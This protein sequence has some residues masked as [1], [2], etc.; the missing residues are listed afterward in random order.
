MTVSVLIADLVRAGVDPELVG[1]VAEALAN[2]SQPVTP[3]RSSAAERQARYRERKAEK[4]QYADEATHQETVT[5]YVTT[6]T[7]DAFVTLKEIPPTPPKE[8]NIYNIPLAREA[9]TKSKG[10]RIPNN[11]QP[12]PKLLELAVG[13]GFSEPELTD[14]LER[15]R[16]WANSAT[17]QVGLKR[18]WQAAFRNWIKRAADDKRRFKSRQSHGSALREA[19]ADQQAFLSRNQPDAGYDQPGHVDLDTPF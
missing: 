8:N 10:S 11:F 14:Q 13:L 12:E 2:A 6:V 15:F 16:D 19:F 9:S 1:R 3:L 4:L 5:R 7:S 17:G 18:D